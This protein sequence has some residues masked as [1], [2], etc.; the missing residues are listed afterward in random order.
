MA[1][2]RTTSRRDDLRRSMAVL[3]EARG[4]DGTSQS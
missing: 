4:T 1:W 3:W 2:E